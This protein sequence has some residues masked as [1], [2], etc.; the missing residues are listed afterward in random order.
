M[1]TPLVHLSDSLS[2]QD[3]NWIDKGFQVVEKVYRM[4]K[5]SWYTEKPNIH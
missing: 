3:K 2:L 4:I 1:Q 5:S